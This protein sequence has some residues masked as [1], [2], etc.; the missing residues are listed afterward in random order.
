VAGA[1]GLRQNSSGRSGLS[2]GCGTAAAA[3]SG[4][5]DIYTQED[6]QFSPRCRLSSRRRDRGWKPPLPHTHHGKTARINRAAVRAEQHSDLIWVW[7]KASA[8]SL[9]PLSPRLVDLCN[10]CVDVRPLGDK[11]AQGRSWHL[12]SD[13]GDNKMILPHGGRHLEVMQTRAHAWRSTWCLPIAQ[14]ERGLEQ[15]V[16]FLWRN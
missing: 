1:G 4:H 15:S 11:S 14:M 7:L 5:H 3:G 2:G 9:R 10:L 8:T 12:P 13:V 16:G 6:A